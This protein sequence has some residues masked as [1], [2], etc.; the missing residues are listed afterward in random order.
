M[1]KIE[2]RPFRY[3]IE[4]THGAACLRAESKS[5]RFLFGLIREAK[6]DC[7]LCKMYKYGKFEGDQAPVHYCMYY[8]DGLTEIM[9]ERKDY[10]E[11]CLYRDGR[12]EVNGASNCEHYIDKDFHYDPETRM[13]TFREI[14]WPTYIVDYIV[15]RILPCMIIFFVFW[16]LYTLIRHLWDKITNFF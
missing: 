3:L 4:A 9:R 13:L 6:M 1:I 12:I 16:A 10:P 2:Y 11:L 15:D 5:E 14:H 8:N 7:R